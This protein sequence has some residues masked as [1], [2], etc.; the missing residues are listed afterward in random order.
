VGEAQAQ[1]G[2]GWARAPAPVLVAL[3]LAAAYLRTLAPGITWANDGSDS[4]DLVTAVG[5][6]SAEVTPYSSV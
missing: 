6:V 3:V 5:D 2:A 4:G 1:P